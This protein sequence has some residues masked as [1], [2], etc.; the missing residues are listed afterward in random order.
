MESAGETIVS[1][2]LMPELI[3]EIERLRGENGRLRNTFRVNVLRWFPSTS[4]AEIDRI[5]DG[6]NAAP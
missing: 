1:A 4:H 5:L 2:G 6:A 3:A